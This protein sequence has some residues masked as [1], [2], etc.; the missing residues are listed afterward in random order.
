MALN[1]G[2]PRGGGE[3]DE[4][5]ET[6]AAQLAAIDRATLTPLVQGALGSES[7]EVVNWKFEQLHGGIGTGTAVYRF[8]GQG[9]DQGQTMPWSLI[10]KILRPE[11]GSADACAWNYYKREADAYQSGWLDDLP[12]GLAAPRCF[13]LLDHPEGDCWIWLEDVRDE[14]GPQW[15]LEQYRIVARHAGQF[16]GAFLVDRP[17]PGWSWLSVGWLRQ[18]VEQ[19]APALPLLRDSLDH[20]LVRR[21]WPGDAIDRFFRLWEERD[22]FLDALDRLP[23]TICHLDVF[24]R[25][26][27]ACKMADGGDQ[28]VAV[29]LGVCG[30]GRNRARTGP[31]CPGQCRVL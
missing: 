15:P 19:A 30:A 14:I 1:P 17:L 13:G 5:L 21:A 12:G 26:L 11:G 6:Q 2:L 7:V 20:P 3:M 4:K 22:L 27:F 9:R 16:N 23:Q 25:N 18:Y 10:L 31:P 29:G 28:T 8:S 24:R